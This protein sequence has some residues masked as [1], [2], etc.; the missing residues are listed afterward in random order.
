MLGINAVAVHGH[1]DGDDHPHHHESS[2][3]EQVH[4]H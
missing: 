1:G 3:Y 2:I 4:E